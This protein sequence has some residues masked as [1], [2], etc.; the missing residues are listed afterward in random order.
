MPREIE[1][2]FYDLFNQGAV[3]GLIGIVIFFI[4]I[5]LLKSFIR[6]TLPNKILVIT[7]RRRIKAGRKFGF[8]VE[9]GRTVMLPYI[10]QVGF[11]DLGVLP[12][13]VRVDGVNSANGITVGADATAC[14][15]IDND[16]EAM[17]YSA[18]ERL[19]GKSRGEIHEQIQS[20][21]VGNF[22]GALN[23]ATPLQAIGM[24]DVP[25][26]LLSDEKQNGDGTLKENGDGG[27]VITGERAQFRNE[28]LKDINSDLSSFGMKVVS[29][30][31]QKIWDSSN[32]IANLAQKTLAQKRQQVEIEEARLHA[33]AMKAESDSERRI[34]IATSK[35]DEQIISAREKLEVYRQ[36]SNALIEKA[37]LQADNEILEAENRGEKDVQEL[38]VELNK[39]KNISNIILEE[40]ANHKA[41]EI[42]SQGE[43]EATNILEQIRN[44][45]LKQKVDILA[46]SGDGGKAVLFIQQQLPHLFKEYKK[47]AEELSVDSYVIMDNK[48]GFNG[49]VNKGPAAFVNFLKHFEEALGI[50]VKE[51]MGEDNKEA[52]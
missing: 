2:F 4:F 6:V 29:V 3:W 43:K 46:K 39:L 48:Q 47:Y 52:E 24:E 26:E 9:K 31:L 15:C 34:S 50:N 13:N 17:L 8:S 19:M 14:V 1:R 32:Y 30:S 36:E 28:L 44:D 23:K 27:V 45:I 18:V 5:G 38:T 35:A 25:D 22:R 37:K 16:N 20:T 41:A 11:L 49:A 10:Q 7:G 33:R 51:L 40:D 21:L 12:I 42:I